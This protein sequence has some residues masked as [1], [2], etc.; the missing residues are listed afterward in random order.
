V[1]RNSSPVDSAS[2][3]PIDD[4]QSRSSQSGSILK[5]NEPSGLAPRE[6]HWDDCSPT[7]RRSDYLLKNVSYPFVEISPSNTV[8]RLRMTWS[9]MVAEFV[10]STSHDRIEY[11]FCAPRHLFVAFEQGARRDGET[12]VEGLPKSTRRD[13]ARKLTFVPA[14][15]EYHEWHDPRIPARLMFFYFDPAELETHSTLDF[16]NVSF[17]P[18]LFFED[19]TLLDTVFKLK[20]L[21]ES[22]EPEN[23]LYFEALAIVLVHELVRLDRGADRVEAQVRGGLAAWQQ[24]VVTA[25]ID[26][27]LTDQ[28]S[29]A[30]LAQL[31]RL[32]PY[33]FCRAF[34]RSFG[35]PPHKYHTSRR[36]E[37]AKVLLEKRPLSVTDV[38]LTLGFSET[39]SF[40][41]A[42]RKATGLTPSGY[43]RS[44]VGVW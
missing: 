36:I 27:H 29:L 4:V 32:S 10:Q 33:H 37:R 34:K 40:T 39:S 8:K 42:F 2:Y 44:L 41:A 14:G 11:R 24:R 31:A 12:F 5:M 28:I 9:G 21:I 25:Y 43:H 22:P 16:S 23:R 1:L 3:D 13:L 17:T 20:R 38:G 19:S 30:T 7:G 35:V 6:R 18:R 15:H 26:E